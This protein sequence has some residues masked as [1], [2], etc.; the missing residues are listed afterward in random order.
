MSRRLLLSYLLLALFVLAV[1]EIP[2]GLSYAR[3]QRNDLRSRLEHDAASFATMSESLFTQSQ[4]VDRQRLEGDAVRYE[5]QYGERFVVVDINGSKILDSSEPGARP[6]KFDQPTRPEVGRAL[7]GRVASGTRYSADLGENLMYVAVPVSPGGATKGAVRVT[8]STTALDNRVRRFWLR[9]GLVALVIMGAAALVGLRFAR[10]ITRPLRKLEQAATAAGHG[11]LSARADPDMGPPEV[12]S[13]AES[14][15]ETVAKLESLI[16]SQEAF[17][18]DAAHQLRTPLAALQLGLENL[19]HDV[20]AEG[21]SRLESLRAEV[22]RLSR[23]AD[24]LL[25]LARADAATAVPEVIDLAPIVNQRLDAWDTYVA[26]RYVLLVRRIDPGLTARATP[27]RIEQALDNLLANALDVSPRAGTITVT[28]TSSGRWV[29]LHVVDQGPGMS[30]Q[31]RARAFDRLWRARED[32]AGAG[33][34]LAIVKRLVSADGGESELLP[35]A[36]G[37]IDAV[38]RLRAASRRSSLGVPEA[39]EDLMRGS[40]APQAIS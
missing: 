37:G 28:G 33:L 4:N 34:G 38:I 1:V 11:D 22:A 20:S 3:S 19:E 14:F 32:S 7:H 36:T 23:L 21:S 18:A 24:G 31:E 2:L 8:T 16:R 40:K 39:D 29:E 15:N 25:A 9:L 35:A 13:L 30:A 26:E 12:R 5:R 27:D 10:S 6:E 17:V